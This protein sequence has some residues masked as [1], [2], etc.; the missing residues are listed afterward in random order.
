M[1]ACGTLVEATMSGD[2]L[3]AWEAGATGDQEWGVEVEGRDGGSRSE[4]E[5][6]ASR[7]EVL[8]L[9]ICGTYTGGSPGEVGGT[10]RGHRRELLAGDNGV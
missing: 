6:G 8:S 2:S 7:L 5:D 10:K 3:S 9:K 4:R 1:D